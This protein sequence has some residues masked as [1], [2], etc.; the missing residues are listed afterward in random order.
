MIA[1]SLRRFL[2]WPQTVLFASLVLWPSPARAAPVT[3]TFTAQTQSVF[4]GLGAL[5]Q[6]AAPNSAF[7]GTFTFDF[8]TPN[9]AQP[10]D[11]GEAGLYHHDAPPAGIRMQVGNFLFRSTPA[12]SDFD[13]IVN[14]EVGFSGAD[15]YGFLSR[16]NEARGLLTG[17]PIGRL[18]NTH[19]I[20]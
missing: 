9:T 17:L 20:R 6:T 12:E 8:Q 15:E 7:T 3:F 2:G 18:D 16:S 13:I 10:V 19:Q 1:L 4:D 14:N 11:E 5:D